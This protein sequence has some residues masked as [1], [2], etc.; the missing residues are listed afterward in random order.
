MI[1]RSAGGGGFFL[2]GL[3]F[4]DDFCF[5]AG[6]GRG[7]GFGVAHGFVNRENLA[8]GGDGAIEVIGRLESLD[9]F[10]FLPQ[11]FL[12]FREGNIARGDVA[13]AR[14]SLAEGHFGFFIGASFEVNQAGVV[15]RGRVRVERLGDF[16]TFDGF[17]VFLAF[18]VQNT[19]AVVGGGI[20]L[21]H[22]QN[23]QESFFGAGGFMLLHRSLGDTPEFFHFGVVFRG[24]GSFFS[25][26]EFYGIQKAQE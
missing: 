16:E 20:F 17:A 24:M 7:H 5:D 21:V 10:L 11:F 9:R 18:R 12:S 2:G 3:G 13:F 25:L 26:A 4:F 14:E 23:R 1:S 8:E 22:F 6:L 19:E 15:Q